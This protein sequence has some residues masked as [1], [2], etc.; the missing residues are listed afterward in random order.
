MKK[1]ALILNDNNLARNQSSQVNYRSSNTGERV[2]QDRGFLNSPRTRWKES[3][4]KDIPAE[5]LVNNQLQDGI[6]LGQDLLVKQPWNSSK[7]VL[8]GLWQKSTELMDSVADN[9]DPNIVR[10]KKF[11]MLGGA[12]LFMIFAA[13]STFSLI[14][15]YLTGNKKGNKLIHFADACMKWIMGVG[16]W[17]TAIGAAG[18]AKFQGLYPILM[19]TGIS[20][21]LSQLSGFSA[22]EKN[23]LANASTVAGVKN[24]L[25]DSVDNLGLLSKFVQR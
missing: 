25:K 24:T 1:Q 5:T 8:G 15:N 4:H 14:N 19:G 2:S 10:M 7:A 3:L 22:G 12:V 21:F 9:T 20:A 11:G 6:A 23:L 18:K 13:K 17:Y 16:I